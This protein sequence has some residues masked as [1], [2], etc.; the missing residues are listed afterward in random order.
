MS[1]SILVQGS[2]VADPVSRT[3]AGGKEFVTGS[4]R[5]PIDGADS[6]LVS[7]IAFASE[8]RALLGAL[9]KGDAVVCTGSA[10]LSTWD[11]RD[12]KQNHGLS[13]V[14]EGI[15]TLSELSKRRDKAR[16]SNSVAEPA[17]RPPPRGKNPGR[18]E[19]MASDLPRRLR[20]D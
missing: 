15:L 1:L 10:K 4:I 20:Y 7:A 11:G 2:L 5:V 16:A 8:T 3:G 19:D 13:L 18:L 12:G 6:I 17:Q 14:A 9:K